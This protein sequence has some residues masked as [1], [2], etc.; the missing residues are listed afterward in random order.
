[1]ESK[2][3]TETQTSK[4]GTGDTLVFE[5]TLTGVDKMSPKEIEQVKNR[6]IEEINAKFERASTQGWP[7]IK[8]KFSKQEHTK[9]EGG[10]GPK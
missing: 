3:P 2:K 8:G 5:A 7:T 9:V 4:S 6:L 10:L 1:M